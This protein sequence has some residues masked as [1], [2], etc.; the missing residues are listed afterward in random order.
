MK[1]ANY[2]VQH[3]FIL[4]KRVRQAET[5]HEKDICLPDYNY[6]FAC[7]EIAPHCAVEH[8]LIGWGTVVQ[9]YLT[10]GKEIIVTDTLTELFL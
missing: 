2:F 6:I 9:C 7:E 10:F 4:L 3:W 1:A 8:N 5:L